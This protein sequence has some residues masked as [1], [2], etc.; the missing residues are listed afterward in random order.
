MCLQISG[1]QEGTTKKKSNELAAQIS[2]EWKAMS[3]EQKEA[4]TMEGK[5]ELEEHRALKSTV[6]HN[7]PIHAYHDARKTL[8]C[9][10][11]EVRSSILSH[12]S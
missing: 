6:K 10:E 5:D 2:A 11:K 7:V 4:A 1:L 12:S 9:I 3:K 8:E